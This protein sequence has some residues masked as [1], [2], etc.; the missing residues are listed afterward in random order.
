MNCKAHAVPTK[1]LR[2]GMRI[3]APSLRLCGL[4]VFAA[5]ETDDDAALSADYARA[6]GA[7]DNGN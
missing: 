3:M 7:H 4:S 6:E 5:I 1:T 2:S